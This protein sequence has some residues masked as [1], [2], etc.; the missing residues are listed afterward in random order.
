M[1]VLELLL[2]CALIIGGWCV[3]HC[4]TLKAERRKENRAKA[5]TVVTD[6]LELEEAAIRFHCAPE[7]DGHANDA[8]ARKIQR[9]T[10]IVR[11]RPLDK[12]SIDWKILKEL[13]Q[14]ITRK[15]TDQSDFKP[16]PAGSEIVRDIRC[17]VDDFISRIEYKKAEIWP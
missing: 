2:N 13:R 9:I 16:Q 14:S 7:F 15:N 10:Q 3:V 11:Q 12:L 5:E 17:A 4:L 6:L 1:K 8:L